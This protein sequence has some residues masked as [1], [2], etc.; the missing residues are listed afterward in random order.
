MCMCVCVCLCFHECVY[1]CVCMRACVCVCVCVCV[2]V[3]VCVC[4]FVCLCVCVYM[5]YPRPGFFL[6]HQTPRPEVCIK[7]ARQ[8]FVY[9]F[10]CITHTTWRDSHKRRSRAISIQRIGN[11]K[12]PERRELEECKRVAK[13]TYIVTTEEVFPY[14][15]GFSCPNMDTFF[16]S[17]SV[18]PV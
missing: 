6:L 17:H 4:V 5:H 8:R 1:V 7:K 3:C 12:L 2:R 15:G 16:L 10:L 14:M 13:Q 11:E 9:I 18:G